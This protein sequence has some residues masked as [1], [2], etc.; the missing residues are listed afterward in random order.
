MP[1]GHSQG[2]GF[3]IPCASIP[4]TAYVLRQ[5]LSCDSLRETVSLPSGRGDTDTTPLNSR[6]SPKMNSKISL[7][8]FNTRPISFER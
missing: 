1:F 8:F 7:F 5:V 3:L 2:H 4:V 6:A